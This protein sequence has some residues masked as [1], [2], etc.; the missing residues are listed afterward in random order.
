MN[1]AAQL[2]FQPQAD[3]G[4]IRA[5]VLAA[6]VHGL[7]FT[8]LY[9]GI[10]WQSKPPEP[11]MADLWNALPAMTAAPA[12]MAVPPAP[13]QPPKIEQPQPVEPPPPA[14]PE[15]RI[16]EPEKKPPPLKKVELPKPPEPQ[17]KPEV[18]AEPKP[19]PPKPLPPAN[20]SSEI[21]KELNKLNKT[22]LADAAGKELEQRKSG[23]AARAA[24]TWGERVASLV[25]SRVPVSV[26]DAVPGNPTATFEVALLP[27]PEVGSVKLL[28]SSGNAAYDEAAE[29]AIRA[30]SPLPPFTEGMNPPRTFRLDASPKDKSQR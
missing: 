13:E 9:F 23:A 15:I 12:P 17:K 10:R 18:K 21:D 28:K 29:R 7:L 8:F 22:A 30:I 14:P 2:P 26:A 16:K 4:S 20:F 24:S 19:L 11:A 5:F 1:A 3:R 6:V 25:R 27:G